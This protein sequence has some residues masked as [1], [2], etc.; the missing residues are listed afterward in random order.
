VWSRISYAAFVNVGPGALI[1]NS[2]NTSLV[3]DSDQ[4]KVLE[5]L[6]AVRVRPSMY[7][8]D[9]FD[10]GYHHLAYEVIDNSVDEALAGYCD[11]IITTIHE[12]GSL[13]IED[14]GR[15]IP[16]S[17]HSSEGVSGV[18]V[19]MTKLHAGGKFEKEAYK[20][21]GGL[22]GVGVSVVN[23][24]SDWLKVTVR[25][26]GKV[27]FMEFRRGA[28]VAPLEVVG[29][30]E[31]TGTKVHF[32]PD[33]SIFKETKAFDFD[34]LSHRIR[35]LAFL[36]GGLKFIVHDKRD[37][38]KIEF[39]Y[40]GGI[41]SFVEHINKNKNPIFEEP[42]FFE[43]EREGIVVGVAL[44]Y[45]KEYKET[46]FT[47]ANNINTTEGGTHLAGFKAAITRTINSYAVKNDLLKGIKDTI[48]GDDTREG[49]AA[50]I[51]VKIPEPQFEGQTKTKLGNSEVKGITEQIVGEKLASFLEQ[52]PGVGKLIVAK[53]IEAAR[54]R[55]AAKKARELV[56]RKG[57]LDSLALPGKL[58]DCQNEDPEKC[59][60]FLVEGDSAGG[61]AKQARDKANQAILPLRG[62]ILN[63]E[64]ARFDKMLSFEE[65]RTIITALG[66][67]IGSEDFNP[68][69]LRYH[70]IV[71]MTDA[72][73]DGSHIRTLLLTFFYRQMTEL[74]SRGN[75]YIAQPPL[76]RVKRGRSESYIKD[77]KSFQELIL[78]NG[79]SDLVVNVDGESLSSETL[80]EVANSMSGLP[81]LDKIF[82]EEGKDP[83]VMR[84]LA[85]FEPLNSEIFNSKQQM[86]S[87]VAFV[88]TQLEALIKGGDVS[89]QLR[90]GEE[91]SLVIFSRLKGVGKKTTFNRATFQR[92]EF[93]SLIRIIESGRR[94]GRGAVTLIEGGKEHVLNDFLDFPGFVD[95][96]GRKGLSITRY[97]G[98]GEMNPD[99]LWE[100]TMDPENRTFL[101]V[102][103]EDAVVADEIF[104]V[105]MGDQVEPRRKFIEENALKTRNLDV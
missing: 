32:Y 40:E 57:A 102:S 41:K 49:L 33:H 73:V 35:E 45:N 7:I 94:L 69:K 54:A 101:R 99:Q 95:K 5:G 62:K 15:G 81:G 72:D 85:L 105:L 38:R 88:K 48:S 59:E 34:V 74:V 27:H 10:K 12:D 80:L 31:G 25:Q 30:A 66:T 13:S 29:T 86:D 6:E 100:T 87:L 89:V 21:S 2:E 43:G 55:A 58:A 11:L 14:N 71:I 37:D 61:S 78:G 75:L 90:E 52:N 60:I 53:S 8:G 76:Y 51:S 77:E 79:C 65:I 104:S 23:A 103:V 67:G 98:L 3:Y 4:I 36:N 44:Q 96:R 97:K 91:L 64:K 50:V 1:M 9:T 63:V 18:Q 84:A 26:G 22:H 68:D 42:V 46:I 39:F 28:P 47:Y 24:L 20:V 93:R 92:A 70:K 83:R 17:L 56:R 19:V 16:T 82:T